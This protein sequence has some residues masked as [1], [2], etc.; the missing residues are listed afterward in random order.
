[1]KQRRGSRA[2]KKPPHEAM[3]ETTIVT[4]KSRKPKPRSAGPIVA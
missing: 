4:L 2:Q 3:V 1:M